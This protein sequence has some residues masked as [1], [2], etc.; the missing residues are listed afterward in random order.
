MFYWPA[1]SPLLFPLSPP[2]PFELRP[3]SCSPM[4][5]KE[6]RLPVRSGAWLHWL[7]PVR[8]RQLRGC[9]LRAHQASVEFTVFDKEYFHGSSLV[10]VA[11]FADR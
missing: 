11:S 1:K 5:S 8:L 7:D 10:N 3:M 4:T 2:Q 6:T 9:V